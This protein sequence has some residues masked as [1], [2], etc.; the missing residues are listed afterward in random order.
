MANMQMGMPAAATGQTSA[1]AATGAPQ[2]AT[3]KAQEPVK[4]ASEPQEHPAQSKGWHDDSDD[5]E[6]EDAGHPHE[7]GQPGENDTQAH[8][9]QTADAQPTPGNNN[10]E[11]YGEE[12]NDATA[13]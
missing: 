2:M 4:A 6:P 8:V 11:Q 7:E 10:M 9:G 12:V 5:G 1:S 3:E 13:K